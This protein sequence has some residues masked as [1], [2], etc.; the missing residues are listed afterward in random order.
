M[1]RFSTYEKAFD[2]LL[3]NEGLKRKQLNL[4]YLTAH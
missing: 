2:E 4:V 3:E 1:L